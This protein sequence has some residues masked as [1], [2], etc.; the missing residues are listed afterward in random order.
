MRLFRTGL[1]FAL[2]LPL[3]GCFEEP[4]REHLHL[5]LRG[6]GPVVV[7]VVQEVTPSDD[8]LDDNPVLN[9]RLE[10][11]RDT[12]DRG[13]DPWSRRFALLDPLAEHVS[14]ER[15]EGELLR[16]IHSAV[17]PSF[18]EVLQIV[19]ADGLTGSLT[20]VDGT[21]ELELFPTGGSRATYTQ[22]QDADR[23]LSEWSAVLAVYFEAVADL[24]AHLDERPDRAVPCF[25]HIFDKHEGPGSTGELEPVEERLVPRV[26][27]AME[28][29]TFA[30]VVDDGEAFSLN[31]LTRLVYDPFP[32]RLTIAVSGEVGES[33]GLEAGAGFFERPP[34]DA[35]NALRSLEGRWISPDLVTAAAAPVSDDRQ[36]DPDV[37]ALA[38]MPRRYFQ[39]PDAAEVES[40]IL[41]GLV[42]EEMLRLVWRPPPAADASDEEPVDWLAV[43]AKAESSVPD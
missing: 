15:V 21:A 27:D 22:R 19:E 26:K 43:M 16:S 20:V 3:V 25:A 36:P 18:D 28:E 2:C 23:R 39:P 38:S 1:V 11:S 34:V 8:R 17:L 9:D 4:V 24:Y 10:E 41:A 7:T 12:I 40:S 32:A 29:I 37:L 13:L 35:W 42:P 14:V 31:E 33:E 30:L 5:T 6:S